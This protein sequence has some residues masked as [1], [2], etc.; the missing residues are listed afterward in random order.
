MQPGAPSCTATP[1]PEREDGAIARPRPIAVVVVGLAY[2]WFAS[3]VRTFTQPAEVLTGV[4]IVLVAIALDRSPRGKRDTDD[5]RPARWLAAWGGL[6][7]A[8]TAWELGEL[9]SLPRHDHPTMSSIGDAVLRSARVVHALAFAVWLV[10]G[11]SLA[12]RG[13]AA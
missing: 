13:R 3:G 4:P 12:R 10:L 11:W 9:K 5:A 2:A 7:L 8:L 6:A 1:D